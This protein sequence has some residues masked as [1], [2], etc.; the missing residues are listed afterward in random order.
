[1]IPFWA[2]LLPSYSAL[3]GIPDV[4]RPRQRTG[5]VSFGLHSDHSSSDTT[6]GTGRFSVLC[7][8]PDRSWGFR[9]F[10]KKH[11]KTS[12]K[13]PF[14]MCL[15]CVF[16]AHTTP[17]LMGLKVYAH[18]CPYMPD[19]PG[20]TSPGRVEGSHGSPRLVVSGY[21]GVLHMRRGVCAATSFALRCPFF[22]SEW[23]S[24]FAASLHGGPEFACGVQS[25]FQ[26][27]R[28]CLN[29]VWSTT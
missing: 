2:F 20:T 14:P 26:C 28:G 22:A 24:A 17:R 10:S 29:Y 21:G 3:S 11:P 12:K 6:H 8:S 13:R 15:T 27:S 7:Q 18:L 1:M 16:H 9:G 19:P 4:W 5:R 25:V 23:T